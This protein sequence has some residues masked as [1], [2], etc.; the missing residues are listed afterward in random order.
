MFYQAALINSKH[1]LNFVIAHNLYRLPMKFDD[2]KIN[3]Y[4]FRV[5]SIPNEPKIE[6]KIQAWERR[7][8]RP[9]APDV[10]Q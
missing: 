9:S 10:A 6:P 4:D 7:I 3:V 5:S 8:L 1:H 2:S